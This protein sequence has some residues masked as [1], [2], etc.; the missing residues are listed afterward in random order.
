M[1]PN[2]QTKA[3]A[4]ARTVLAFLNK[5]CY[6]YSL[7]GGMPIRDLRIESKDDPEEF[8]HALERLIFQRTE[9]FVAP[10]DQ[11][12]EVIRLSVQ[13]HMDILKKE[14]GDLRFDD[15]ERR[16]YQESLRTHRNILAAIDRLHPDR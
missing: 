13:D 11:W 2:R 4:S 5:A 6:A 16:A 7:I 1:M 14:L 12:R 10:S 3:E 15:D 9:A 8:F